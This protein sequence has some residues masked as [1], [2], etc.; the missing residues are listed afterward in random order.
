MARAP[1]PPA[2][3]A[4]LPGAAASW[5]G[6]RIGEEWR[7]GAIH[8]LAIG[9]PRTDGLAI[10]PRDPRPPDLAAGQRLLAGVFRF[11]GETLDVG[12]G[13]DPWRRPLP[14]H[15]FALALHRFDWGHDLLSGGEAGAR[16]LLRLWADWRREF[17][18]FNAFAW[19]GEALERR[20]FNLACAASDLAPLVSDAEGA[21]FVD[22]L[23]RQ[24]RHLMGDP[25]DPGRAAERAAVAALAGAALAGKAGGTLLPRALARL[26]RLLPQAVLRD[27][28]HASRS[29][30]RGLELLFD[31]MALDDALSQRGAPPPPE[32]SRAIDRLSAGVRLFAGPD[33]RLAAFQ[34]GEPGRAARAAAALALDAA[35]GP[36][37]KSAPYG[38]YQRLEG[39][40]VRLI[41]D[42]GAPPPPAFAGAGCA[43]PGA[44][45]V[46]CEGRRLIEGSVWSAK[47]QV[48]GALRGPAGGS[49]LGLGQALPG[50]AL[51]VGLL[52]GGLD[53]L[54]ASGPV[55]V[56]VERHES[57]EAVWLDLVHDG[58]LWAGLTAR[59]RLFLDLA[60]DELRGEDALTP[61]GGPVRAAPM[62]VRFQLSPGVAAQVAADG[63][64]AL[65]RPASGQGWRLRSDA[66]ETRLESGVAFEAGEPRAIQTLVLE[67]AVPPG[68]ARIRWKLSRDQ[69]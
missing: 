4:S 42:A 67:T 46:W 25:G 19:T 49:C 32:L 13:G 23:A 64:S 66:A 16:Q 43:Q 53:E 60:A 7:A 10:R 47:A 26:D 5:V 41:V 62:L 39:R 65:L 36:P 54:L 15:R 55:R 24:A 56:E 34:G 68:G 51:R 63:G 21:A 69:G 27:G 37:A 29:P 59:R 18:A 40:R 14:S 30:E 12:P 58:W 33:G 1:Q 61:A 48:G 22:G 52:A 35:Q 2:A 50:A 20:V 17:G 11:A 31:L 38:G 8:R 45:A 9:R 3:L 6:R 28:V 57:D 44:I